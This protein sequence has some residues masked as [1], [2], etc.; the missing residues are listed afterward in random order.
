[1]INTCT[2]CSKN[3]RSVPWIFDF[4]LSARCQQS[5]EFPLTSRGTNF[6]KIPHPLAVSPKNFWLCIKGWFY[7]AALDVCAPARMEPTQS[8]DKKR[9]IKSP[10]PFLLISASLGCCDWE[11][12]C[13][14]MK[15]W[16]NSPTWVTSSNMAFEQIGDFFL[17]ANTSKGRKGLEI[18]QINFASLW[19]PLAECSFN[20]LC[21]LAVTLMKWKTPECCVLRRG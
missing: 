20:L 18:M 13:R 19:L 1:M 10:E 6:I 9:R 14:E 16:Y 3:R 2:W 11:G 12:G 15:R 21:C 4:V 8:A 7:E 5:A 17:S